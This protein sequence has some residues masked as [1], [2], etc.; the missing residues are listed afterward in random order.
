LAPILDVDTFSKKALK[1]KEILVISIINDLD[2]Y[3]GTVFY[4]TYEERIF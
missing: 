3:A 1:G 4:F 2:Y